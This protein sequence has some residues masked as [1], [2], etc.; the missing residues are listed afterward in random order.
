MNLRCIIGLHKYAKFLG[1]EN[2][3]GGRFRQRYRL[4]QEKA[5]SELRS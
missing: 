4:N 3:G 1:P 5:L 2:I